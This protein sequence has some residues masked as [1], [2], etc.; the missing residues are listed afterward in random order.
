MKMDYSEFF[1]LCNI[2]MF[3]FTIKSTGAFTSTTTSK[4][5]CKD[6]NNNDERTEMIVFPS[7]FLTI[8]EKLW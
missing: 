5:Y 2:N 1:S 6:D 4:K 8:N 3:Y 7:K